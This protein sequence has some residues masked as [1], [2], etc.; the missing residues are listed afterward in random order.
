MESPAGD[1]SIN[2][3]VRRPTA[4]KRCNTSKVQ[5]APDDKENGAAPHVPPHRSQP[6]FSP[7]TVMS[8]AA[9]ARVFSTV[10]VR[11]AVGQVCVEVRSCWPKS[12]SPEMTSAP[13]PASGVE[14]VEEDEPSSELLNVLL[15]SKVAGVDELLAWEVA[16]VD[17]LL[18]SEVAGVDELLLGG[19]EVEVMADDEEA[20]AAL[21]AP[22]DE[23]GPPAEEDC[24]K[25]VVDDAS[26]L[27]TA[28]EV[29]DSGADE[30]E[31]PA[32]VH[33]PFTHHSPLM[34]GVPKPHKHTPL[35][36][37]RSAPEPHATQAPPAVPHA[38]TEAAVHAPS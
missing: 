35:G 32:A 27:D 19:L 12:T 38:A 24:D 13:A 3:V 37:Q 23:E 20:M 9:T 17:E 14:L 16:G 5:D 7:A 2:S 8:V 6:L 10:M 29:L 26:E 33:C 28:M 15:V 36:P 11:V 1:D 18:V 30:E 34:H 4:L 21:D 25:D 31:E 22:S